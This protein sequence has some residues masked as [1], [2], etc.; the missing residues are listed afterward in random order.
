MKLHVI[1][2]IKKVYWGKMKWEKKCSEQVK[3]LE[4]VGKVVVTHCVEYSDI[5]VLSFVSQCILL[6][7]SG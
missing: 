7:F 1:K 2:I 4:K 3:T 6:V 5:K